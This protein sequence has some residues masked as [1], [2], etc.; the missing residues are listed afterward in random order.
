MISYPQFPTYTGSIPSFLLQII[1]WIL[2][3]PLIAIGNMIIGVSGSATNSLGTGVSTVISF[4]ATIFRQSEA[5]FRAYGVFA[6]I[7]VSLIW[8]VSIIIL[9]FFIFKAVQIAGTEMTNDV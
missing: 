7:I 4:P 8:G 9:I 5:S 6:P 1:L 3:I 2:E